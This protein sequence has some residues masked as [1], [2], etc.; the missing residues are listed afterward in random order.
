MNENEKATEFLEMRKGFKGFWWNF[1][2]CGKLSKED[3]KKVMKK[4]LTS[5]MIAMVVLIILIIVGSFAITEIL[6]NIENS[7]PYSQV[8]IEDFR[9]KWNAAATANPDGITEGIRL[10]KKD[11]SDSYN[12]L[13]TEDSSIHITRCGRDIETLSYTSEKYK[14]PENRADILREILNLCMPDT[15]HTKTLQDRLQY[16]AKYVERAV[17]GFEIEFSEADSKENINYTIHKKYKYSNNII[18][19]NTLTGCAFD[20]TLSEFFDDYNVIVE[21]LF[22][23]NSQYLSIENLPNTLPIVRTDTYGDINIDVYSYSYYNG[24]TEVAA[25]AFFVERISGKICQLRYTLGCDAYNNMSDE[26]KIGYKEN[27]IGA[28][29]GAIGFSHY[30]VYDEYFM[31][32][33]ESTE[34]D[35]KY[36]KIGA[37]AG[38]YIKKVGNTEMFCFEM[39][40]YGE[41]EM[42]ITPDSPSTDATTE[43]NTNESLS[44]DE[45]EFTATDNEPTDSNDSVVQATPQNDI[46]NK[47]AYEII[48]EVSA[49]K[50]KHLNSG[51]YSF[52]RKIGDYIF[53]LS[54]DNDTC[55]MSLNIKTKKIKQIAY[56]EANYN[57]PIQ[58]SST[59]LAFIGSE[60]GYDMQLLYYD[61]ASETLSKV[62]QNSFNKGL[63]KLSGDYLV[64]ATQNTAA[65]GSFEIRCIDLKTNKEKVVYTDTSERLKVLTDKT[66]ESIFYF[67]DSKTLYSYDFALQKTKTVCDLSCLRENNLI[68]NFQVDYEDRDGYITVVNGYLYAFAGKKGVYT[69]DSNG[70][71]VQVSQYPD[72]KYLFYESKEKFVCQ[73]NAIYY[74]AESPNDNLIIKLEKGVETIIKPSDKLQSDQIEFD[75]LLSDS[76]IEIYND[77]VW[78]KI[79]DRQYDYIASVDGEGNIEN[80]FNLD[81]FEII[82]IDD[83]YMYCYGWVNKAERINNGA[84]VIRAFIK[85]K[86]DDTKIN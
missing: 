82:E 2:N 9:E 35:Y 72:N 59:K 54:S 12:I 45:N 22:G 63:P 17:Y 43:S 81:E 56:V 26:L 29:F 83:E 58:F 34:T 23:E 38:A 4:T 39:Y 75:G 3:Q 25:I 6:E 47:D 62:A 1:I 7:K 74:R 28:I 84:D 80:I 57:N 15:D 67:V 21:E 78:Y 65:E 66:S 19:A 64:Y 31:V 33:A 14:D 68:Q 16:E 11:V 55:L 42:E 20:C 24:T 44:N 76:V 5:G 37:Q 69:V 70:K 79:G 77:T 53:Y 32:A 49:I 10:T 36:V 86:I 61:V 51:H 18:A 41:G 85:V 30:S 60:T 71:P 50:Y 27:L 48:S 46:Q 13:S 52:V 73:N 8:E 40:A